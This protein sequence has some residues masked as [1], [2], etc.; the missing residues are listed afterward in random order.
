MYHTI[1]IYDKE[2]DNN[3]IFS[4]GDGYYK[5]CLLKLDFVKIIPLKKLKDK[6]FNCK[7]L[8]I[9]NYKGLLKFINS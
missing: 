7:N 9:A 6:H 4:T 5:L 2:I 3:K 8:L 1:F